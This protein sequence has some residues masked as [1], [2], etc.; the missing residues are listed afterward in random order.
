MQDA[1]MFV[2]QWVAPTTPLE[3]E[4]LVQQHDATSGKIRWCEI[5]RI[6]TIA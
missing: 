2:A 5:I 6:L 3:E 4:I 1:E